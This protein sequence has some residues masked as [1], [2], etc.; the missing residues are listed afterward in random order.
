[1]QFLVRKRLSCLNLKR[2]LFDTLRDFI[3]GSHQMAAK[4]SDLLIQE[5]TIQNVCFN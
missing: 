5:E 3:L 1:M 4:I 2:S